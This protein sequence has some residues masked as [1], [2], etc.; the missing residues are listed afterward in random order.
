MYS[1]LFSGFIRFAKKP[2]Q[3]QNVLSTSNFSLQLVISTSN[4]SLHIMYVSVKY[5]KISEY[6]QFHIIG[7]QW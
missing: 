5:Y 1:K 6:S 3:T 7:Y 2:F 4:F